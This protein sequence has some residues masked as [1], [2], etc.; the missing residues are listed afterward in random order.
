MFKNTKGETPSSKNAPQILTSHTVGLLYLVAAAC[1]VGVANAAAVASIGDFSGSQ[2]IWNGPPPGVD[3][4]TY[5]AG[6]ASFRRDWSPPKGKV[7]VSA[8]ILINADDA[9]T[10]YVNGRKVGTGVNR[11]S[12]ERYCVRLD[13]SCCNV[14]AVEGQNFVSSPPNLAGILAVIQVK[15]TDGFRDTIFSDGVWH[16]IE[17]APAGFEQVAYDDSDWKAAFVQGPWP[18]KPGPGH[19][20]AIPPA[21]ASPG[22]GDGPSLPSANWIWSNDID[23]QGR[24]PL[25]KRA[26]RK[27]VNLPNNQL[28]D[29]AVISI[30]ADDQQTLYVNGLVVASGKLGPANR[31]VVNFPPT[32]TVVIAVY[33]ENTIP[34]YGGLIAAVELL[35]CDCSANTFL[36]TDGTWK[37]SATISPQFPSL[38]FDDSSWPLVKVEGK[39]GDAPFGKTQLPTQNSPQSGPLP[40][41]PPAAPASVAT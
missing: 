12:A 28:V 35:S 18:T 29:S 25:G 34:I 17:G 39:Y 5:P 11:S 6:N 30:T 16:S 32:S 7:P 19:D 10:L 27:T 22:A 36:V 23:A 20:I 9:Y 13:D 8:D 40:G 1:A 31:Y 4:L 41:A 14:F 2:F 15:Y 37:Y 24:A 3:G 38:G 21:P 26:F 33:A